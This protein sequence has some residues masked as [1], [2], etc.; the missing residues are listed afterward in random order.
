MLRHLPAIAL[1][2]LTAL[3]AAAEDGQ[4]RL[5]DGFGLLQEGTRLMLRGLMQELEPALRDMQ[6]R[7]GDLS[8]YHP[9]EILPNGDIIIRRKVPLD[10]D[11][12]PGGEIDL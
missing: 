2:F 1:C 9:P 3:P 6:D 10:V 7:I 12:E 4:D 8:A 5:R 11:A